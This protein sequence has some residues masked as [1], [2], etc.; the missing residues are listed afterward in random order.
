MFVWSEPKSETPS[1][2]ISVISPNSAIKRQN[3]NKNNNRVGFEI[4][5]MNSLSNGLCFL[6]YIESIGLY[7][8]DA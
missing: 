1:T 3:A 5:G 7:R 4:H 8:F 2:T 6:S